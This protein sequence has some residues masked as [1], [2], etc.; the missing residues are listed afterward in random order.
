MKAGYYQFTPEWKNP[1]GTL[2]K[3]KQR[4]K[5]E[6]FDLLVLPEL[7]TTGYLLTEKEMWKFAEN[8]NESRTVE[9]LAKI[10]EVAGGFI[11][12]SIIEK[13]EDDYLYNTA[14][15]VGPEG[16]E[17]S[18]R[19]H[20][21]PDF[22]KQYFSTS[23]DDPKLFDIGDSKAGVLICFD[24]WFPELTR[25]MTRKGL[26]VLCHPAAFSGPDTPDVVRVRAIENR[27][28]IISANMIGEE[29]FEDKTYSYRGASRIVSPDGQI[30]AVSD[31]EEALVFAEISPGDS[32]HKKLPFCENLWAEWNHYKTEFSSNAQP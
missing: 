8:L 19:K 25:I 22:E 23:W 21:L 12:G 31:K 28:F 24:I 9:E 32:N 15:L 4:L 26:Q 18:Y 30:I 7:F 14:V 13:D 29:S 2:Q 10:A 6:K 5:S 20:H 3:I 27:V 11:C 17:G 16:L 1:R